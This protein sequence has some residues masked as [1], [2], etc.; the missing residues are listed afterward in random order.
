MIIVAMLLD[1]GL[2]GA[3]VS[4]SPTLDSWTLDF[5]AFLELYCVQCGLSGAKKSDR[6][7]GIWVPTP[8]GMWEEVHTSICGFSS[9][10]SIHH[11]MLSS[12]F[13]LSIE[14]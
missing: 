12:S 6:P 14:L 5:P 10:L 13:L 9:V 11:Y 4:I 7:D 3:A 1:L 2:R 8:T